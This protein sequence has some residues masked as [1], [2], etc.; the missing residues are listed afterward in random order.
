MGA[1]RFSSILGLIIELG[2]VLVAGM[3][4]YPGVGMASGA[5][6]WRTFGD[7]GGA[8]IPPA[9]WSGHDPFSSVT[10][11]VGRTWFQELPPRTCRMS[12]LRAA[13]GEFEVFLV[14]GPKEDLGELVERAR[15]RFDG[16]GGVRVEEIA[17]MRTADGMIVR[18]E[19]ATMEGG[20]TALLG[21][22]DRRRGMF[23]VNAGG[24]S[25][26]AD[27]EAVRRLVGAL[28]VPQG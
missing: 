21:V 16:Q 20:R 13:D 15:T 7:A 17:P 1:L 28:R 18:L 22:G 8:V 6:R 26:P 25:D 11:Y 3:P 27:V 12:L 24:G 19:R 23:V 14:Y 2:V 9:G 4:D 10:P 5:P